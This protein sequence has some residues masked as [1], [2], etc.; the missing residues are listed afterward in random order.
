MKISSKLKNVKRRVYALLLSGVILGTAIPTGM[1]QGGVAKADEI[2]VTTSSELSFDYSKM[3]FQIT[4]DEGTTSLTYD[5]T[6]ST[7][8]W[9]TGV[10]VNQVNEISGAV[11]FHIAD[12][13]VDIKSGTCFTY[14]F[15]EVFQISDVASKNFDVVMDADTNE[16]LTLGTYEITNNTLVFHFTAADLAS[17]GVIFD[18]QTIGFSGTIDKSKLRTDD[19]NTYAISAPG[20]ASISYIQIPKVPTELSTITKTSELT[21][22]DSNTVKW[23]IELGTATDAGVS[24]AGGTVVETLDG[25]QNFVRAYLGDD[26]SNTLEFVQDEN[27]GNVYTYT[28]PEDSTLEAPQTIT[29]ETTP[30]DAALAPSSAEEAKTAVELV[31]NASFIAK[32]KDAA[33]ALNTNSTASI[34]R[35]SLG[36][37]YTIIDGSTAEWTIDLNS[38]LANVWA[39]TV[40]DPLSKGLTIDES[41]FG[42]QIVEMATDENG[43]KTENGSVTLTSSAKS[44]TLNGVAVSY[45]VTTGDTGAQ[46]LSVT[47]NRFQKEYKIIFRTDISN[48]EFVNDVN[49][50]NTAYV[51][52]SYPV[53]GGSGG[54]PVEYGSPEVNMEFKNAFVAIEA[55]SADATTGLLNWKANPSTKMNASDYSGS[56]L[57]ITLKNIVSADDVSKNGLG[58]GHSFND[59]KVEAVKVYNVSDDSEVTSGFTTLV[60]SDKT[61]LTVSFDNSINLNDIYV[62]FQSY[63][64]TYFADDATHKYIAT[65]DL[66]ITSV[67]STASVAAKKNA[68]QSLKNKMVTKTET[69]SYDEDTNNTLFTFKIAVNGN[70][71]SLTNAVLTDNLSGILYSTDLSNVTSEGKVTPTAS[72]VPLADEDYEIESLTVD[73]AD[74]TPSDKSEKNVSVNLGNISAAS[75]IILTV[76]LTDTGKAKLRVGGNLSQKAIYAKNSATVTAGELDSDGITGSVTGVSANQIAINKAVVKKGS[77]DKEGTNY[78]SDLTW[79]LDINNMGASIKNSDNS[80]TVIVDT[81]PKGLTLDKSSVVLY[82]ATHAS[83]GTL[84]NGAG[85][86]LTLNT[87]YVWSSKKNKDGTTTLTIQLITTGGKDT[88]SYRLKY[89]TAMSGGVATYTNTAEITVGST[90]ITETATVEA[91]TYNSGSGSYRAFLT[92]TKTDALAT[93]VAVK[94]AKY[95]VFENGADAALD[96]GDSTKENKAVDVGYTDENGKITFTVPGSKTNPKTYYVCE[97]EAPEDS[98][99]NGG[100]YAL[101]K[102][103]YPISGVK[104]GS[105]KIGP[106]GVGDTNTFK[107]SRDTTVSSIGTATITNKFFD[108]SEGGKTSSFQLFIYPTSS[109]SDKKQVKLNPDSDGVYTFD[110]FASGVTVSGSASVI[111][112]SNSVGSLQ[113]KELPWGTY[114]LVQTSTAKGFLTASEYVFT[115]TGGDNVTGNVENKKTVLTIKDNVAADYVIEGEFADGSI[116]KTLSGAD[117]TAAGGVVY[118]GLVIQGK[119]YTIKETS[120][121]AGYKAHADVP[122]NYATYKYNGTDSSVVS[123]SEDPIVLKVEVKDQDGNTVSDAALSTVANSGTVTGATLNLNQNVSCGGSYDIT[124]VLTNQYLPIDAEKVTVTVSANGASFTATPTDSSVMNASVSGTTVTIIVQ[125]IKAN[126]AIKE[127]SSDDDTKILTGGTFE[128]FNKDTNTQIGTVITDSNGNLTFADAEITG[129][130][131][132]NYYLMQ[133]STPTSYGFYDNP[134]TNFEFTVDA[135]KHNQVIIMTFRC[136][137]EPGTINVT[138]T[139][140]RGTKTLQGAEYTLYTKDDQNNYVVVDTKTTDAEGKMT[141]D[142]L[143]WDTYYLQETK[144]PSGY[145]LDNTMHGPWII[146]ETVVNQTLNETVTEEPTNVVMKTYGIDISNGDDEEQVTPALIGEGTY[147]VTGIFGGETEETTKT[148]SDDDNDGV[149]TV[150]NEFVL[151]NVYTILQTDVV[152]PYNMVVP[153]EVEITTEIASGA[154]SINITNR[155]NRFAFTL[156]NEYGVAI[157]GAKFTIYDENDNVVRDDILS[158]SDTNGRTVDITNLKPGVYTLKEKEAV[159]ANHLFYA[160]DDSGVKFRLNADNTV[161]ILTINQVATDLKANGLAD[162]DTVVGAKLGYANSTKITDEAVIEYVNTPTIISFETSVRYNEN[163]SS[164]SGDTSGLIGITYGIYTDEECTEPNHVANGTT[165]KNGLVVVAGLPEGTYYTKMLGSDADNIVVDDTVYVAEVTGFTFAGLKYANGTTVNESITLEVNRSDLVLTKTDK[166]DNTNFLAGSTYAIYRK[167]SVGVNETTSYKASK[168]SYT[169]FELFGTRAV[170]VLQQITGSSASQSA[171]ADDE[172]VLVSTAVTDENGKITFSGVDVGVE[173]LIQET[174]EPNGYQVSKDPILV[175][176][177]KQ[178]DGSVKLTTVD[179]GSGTA[180]VDENGNITW[181][182]PR[183]KVAVRLVDEDG[184]VLTGGNFQLVQNTDASSVRTWTSAKDDELFSGVLTG[185]TAYTVVQTGAPDGYIASEDVVFTAEA[186][187]LSATDDYVQLVTVVNKKETAKSDSSDSSDSGSSSDNSDSSSEN[188]A[189]STMDTNDSAKDKSPKTGEWRFPWE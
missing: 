75:N 48:E 143:L 33:D 121:P 8:Q 126:V 54:S 49:I 169:L 27:D 44:K 166:E 129:L 21:N 110:S 6:T 105:I 43:E 25:K 13:R 51:D 187:A 138:K 59:E 80:N 29:V 70:G 134:S 58:D 101:D 31:N 15:P 153:F 122:V 152:S 91:K 69:S 32:N 66:S 180:S 90:P 2:D 168:N 160:L 161:D 95:G 136:E 185:G 47:M 135:S 73:G 139:T 125:K 9:P 132:G 99:G 148:F 163:C 140:A 114:H 57:K 127:V 100:K 181:Y 65:A 116:S 40:K 77:Q 142:N 22:D 144:A 50:S 107:D 174:S 10:G 131:V 11:V 182:E 157:G 30:T 158:L 149:I 179:N 104:F 113:L 67:S 118:T 188:A 117:L 56:E 81:I 53:G 178:A 173:Y 71:L 39:A 103:V 46:T 92:M 176:F 93:S 171:S 133:M 141:F 137:P 83:N 128:L 145:Q 63:A 89:V 38:N 108:D 3:G 88:S 34:A 41:S 14:A 64:D 61:E 130:G 24:L 119:N 55:V 76:G 151:G 18:T 26:T 94:G 162:N 82:K 84:I 156:T 4:T 1:L 19:V 52:V 98:D 87:D 86:A 102:T 177:E 85:D 36:K 115:I 109:A 186:K 172:W 78:T 170:S 147:Q 72:D 79:Y 74:Q 35:T 165:D 97:L 164:S 28:F 37:D 154:E 96:A 189:E 23:S 112:G 42:I 68:I 62:T 17:E 159:E 184:K 146:D 5:S 12:T 175:K 167:S 60:S 155:M 124:G 123:I 120:V 16:T 111:D 7:Y 150:S 20:S 45:D 106:A 183:L